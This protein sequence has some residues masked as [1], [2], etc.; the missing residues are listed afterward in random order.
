MADHPRTDDDESAG[1]PEVTVPPWLRLRTGPTP[2]QSIPT[3][4]AA[5][6]PGPG[7]R[8]AGGADRTGRSRPHTPRASAPN[9]ITLGAGAP[10]DA[11]AEQDVP[12]RR[13]D[14][15]STLPLRTAPDPLTAPASAPDT[16]RTPARGATS[17][18][19]RD[20]AADESVGGASDSTH[21]R[22]RAVTPVSV[23]PGAG[24]REGTGVTARRAGSGRGRIAVLAAAGAAVLA[25]SGVLGYLIARG[26][27]APAGDEMTGCV[28]VDEPGRV[29]GAGPGSLDTPTGAVLAFDH[30]YYVE[31]SAVKAF[32]AVSPSSRMSRERLRTAGVEQ[33]ADGTTHC[34]EATE[35]S[36]TLLDVTVT[37]QTPDADPVHIRQRIRVAENP[38]GTWGIVSIT[39]AG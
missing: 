6:A 22:R 16:A 32:D 8:P 19:G 14:D 20:R 27:I 3:A 29:V 38:D 25:G 11:P 7:E 5:L 18:Q 13:E 24:S 34:V 36:P 2:D 30:A 4:P 26:V 15:L 1:R 37:E 23:F 17:T 35:L 10:V 39:P 28:A 9:R 33:I 21:G 31:R 12:R